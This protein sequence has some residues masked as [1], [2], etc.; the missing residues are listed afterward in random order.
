MKKYLLLCIAILLFAMPINCYA[1]TNPP[2]HSQYASNGKQV[3]LASGYTEDGIYYEVYGEKATINPNTRHDIHVERTVSF[4]G[5]IFPPQTLDWLEEIN[6]MDY[7]GTLTLTS[8]YYDVA[9]N[10]TTGFYEGIIRN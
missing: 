9:A 5:K 2:A 7:V 10:K 4:T 6:G 8:F 3:F 1:N